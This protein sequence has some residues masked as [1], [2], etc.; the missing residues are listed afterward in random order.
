MLPINQIICGNNLDLLKTLPDESIQLIITSPPYDKLRDYSKDINNLTGES[1]YN[2]T[3]LLDCKRVLKNNGSLVFVI[4]DSV[5]GGI[6]SL[7]VNKLIVAA[8]ETFGLYYHDMYIYLKDYIPGDASRRARNSFEYMPMFKKSIKEYKFY[9]DRIRIPAAG[10]AAGRSRRMKDGQLI[11]LMNYQY[12]HAEKDPGNALYFK[13]GSNMHENK[14]AFQ[15]PATFP[16]EIP[17]FFIK[18]LT[19]EGDIILDPFMGSGTVGVAAKQ[20]NR[21]YL[22]FDVSQ[23]YCDIAN[24][25]LKYVA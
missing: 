12:G 9:G 4:D 24:E 15:H 16:L 20:L 14:I 7:T 22:G 6:R 10:S 5:Q 18:L 11:T 1:L 3:F 23:E 21:N 2:S 17:K 19:D 13:A 25:R 8:V